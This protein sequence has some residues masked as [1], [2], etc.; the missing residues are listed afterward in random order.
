M[1]VK[2]I[3][4]EPCRV[5]GVSCFTNNGLK[6]LRGDIEKYSLRAGEEGSV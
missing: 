5:G 1:K 3:R 2:K 6:Q 4:F